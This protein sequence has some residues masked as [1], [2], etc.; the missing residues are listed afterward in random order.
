M[1]ANDSNLADGV[2]RN[3]ITS[4]ETVVEA[5]PVSQILVNGSFLDQS[6]FSISNGLPQLSSGLGLWEWRVQ[7]VWSDLQRDVARVRQARAGC[8]PMDPDGSCLFYYPLYGGDFSDLGPNDLALV[9][10]DEDE[11]QGEFGVFKYPGLSLSP[12]GLRVSTNKVYCLPN[13]A[14]PREQVSS[15]GIGFPSS[16]NS[17]F[18]L[19]FQVWLSLDSFFYLRWLADADLGLSPSDPYQDV[20][21]RHNKLFSRWADGEGNAG[22]AESSHPVQEERWVSIAVQKNPGS[23]QVRIFHDGVL[24]L[25]AEADTPVTNLDMLQFVTDG[26]VV[27]RELSLRSVAPLPV[28]PFTPGPVSYAS[29]IGD[30]QKRWNSYMLG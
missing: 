15:T 1:N 13:R 23:N 9:I 26:E 17:A 30:T 22:S 14:V 4:L 7:P 5:I 8:V 19:E 10:T 24:R 27:V 6:Q 2:L 11:A 3:S 25:T 29:S 18:C 21:L 28:V 20:F 12:H 16:L